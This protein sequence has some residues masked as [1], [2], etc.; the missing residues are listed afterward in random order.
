MNEVEGAKVDS[1]AAKEF[2]F[3]I[4]NIVKDVSLSQSG[5]ESHEN[6]LVMIHSGASVNVLPKWFGKP[7]L[8]K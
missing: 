5:C 4:E 8:E 7:V 2:V 1:D 6:G 3:T